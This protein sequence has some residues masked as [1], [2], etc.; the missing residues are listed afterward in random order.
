MCMYTE[1]PPIKDTPNNGH[2]TN[3][4]HLKD[5]LHVYVV[6]FLSP[7]RGQP[8]YNGQN[9]LSQHVRYLEVPLYI[10]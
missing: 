7:K 6:H 9:D 5:T 3:N 2:N 1:E 4:L 8:L 10:H